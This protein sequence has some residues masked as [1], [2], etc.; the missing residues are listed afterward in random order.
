M[1]QVSNK[2]LTVNCPVSYELWEDEDFLY[3]VH[4]T[5]ILATVLKTLPDTLIT[6]IIE[7]L[8]SEGV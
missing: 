8:R 4:G 3:I 1:I 5:R 7:A 2:L 6:E